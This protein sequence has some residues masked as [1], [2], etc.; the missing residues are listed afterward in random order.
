MVGEE[1]Y[2]GDEPDYA[3]MAL[4]EELAELEHDQWSH[5]TNYLLQNINLDNVLRWKE[6][7]KTPYPKLSEIEKDADR[8]WAN[9]VIKILERYR[10][11]GGLK[12]GTNTEQEKG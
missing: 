5:W 2:L 9:K 10:M 7:I 1:E 11:T 3:D 6:Q 12:N 4:L 8:K